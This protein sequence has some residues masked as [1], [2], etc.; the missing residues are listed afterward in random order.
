M[1]VAHDLRPDIRPDAWRGAVGWEEHDGAVRSWRLLPELV[2]RAFAP[3][4]I[5]NARQSVGV[6]LDVDTDA[7]SIA[8]DGDLLLDIPR[9]ARIDVLVDGE[10]HRRIDLAAGPFT[11]EVPLP[12]GA[13][14]VQAWLPQVGETWIR[15]VQLSGPAAPASPASTR[16]TT[17]GSSIS[18]CNAAS[19]PSETWPAIVAR[20]LDWD[21]TCLGFGGQCHLDPVSTRTIAAV[22]AD[23]VSLCLGIN[24]MGNASMSPR[25][26]APHVAGLIDQVRAA[27]PS[28][29]IA[30]ITPIVAP[31]LESSPNAVGATLEGMRDAL[32]EVVAGTEDGR[33]HLIDGPS[34]LGFDDAHLLSDGVHPDAAGYRLMGERLTTG[35]RQLRI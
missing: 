1:I 21:L 26:F 7:E 16:W 25:A 27:H 18:Q 33:L 6:R 24:V 29:T 34:V 5:T 30:V 13:H 9:D 12:T 4:L 31:G 17:Y 2:D 14:R 15:S 32:A 10:L 28:A 11:L 8:L 3:D 19:G 20:A 23:I 35:L 22:P